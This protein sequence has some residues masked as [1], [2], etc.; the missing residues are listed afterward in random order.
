MAVRAV[1]VVLPLPLVIPE[2]TTRGAPPTNIHT[3]TYKPFYFIPALKGEA[4]CCNSKPPAL[5][6]TFAL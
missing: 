3:N 4:F 6:T 5:A 2:M 1:S